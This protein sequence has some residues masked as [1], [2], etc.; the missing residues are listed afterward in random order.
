MAGRR[1][2]EPAAPPARGYGTF[3]M[4][5]WLF[6]LWRRGLLA[7]RGIN[8]FEYQRGPAECD[9]VVLGQIVFDDLLAVDDGAVFGGQ[10][11]DEEL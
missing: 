1:P 9:A 7:G 2:G 4:Q 6:L 10:V 11:L 3:A 5:T 8:H